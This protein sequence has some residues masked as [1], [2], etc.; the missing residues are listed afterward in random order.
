MVMQALVTGA[1]SGMGAATACHL[2]TR[3]F[4]VTGVDVDAEGLVR[5][6]DAGVTARS[7]VVDLSQRASVAEALADVE[8]DALV[9][10]A[11]LGPDTENPRLIWSVNLLAPMW[12][13]STVHLRSG[14]SIVNVASITGELSDGRHA[15][16]LAHPLRDGFLEEVVLAVPEPVDAY[17]Y[18]KWALLRETDRLAAGLA[19]EVRVNAVSPGVIETPM[20]TRGTKFDWTRKAMERIPAG[21]LGRAEEVAEVIGFLV[22]E[23]ATY[24][25][26]SRVTV[27]GGY[28]AS[29]RTHRAPPPLPGSPQLDRI[30]DEGRPD[31]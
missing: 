24:V 27:D 30:V 18:S 14:G 7:I 9:N 16:L 25:S 17:M 11:G 19:P 8:V 20:G 1:A 29:R 6:Q 23:G 5:L 10:A 12:V 2:A 21:R 26:G 22:S 15:E 28:V 4:A 13:A 31:A 3:G